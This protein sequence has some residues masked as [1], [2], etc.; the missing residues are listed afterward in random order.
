MDCAPVEI[1]CLAVLYVEL[2]CNYWPFYVFSNRSPRFPIV[3]FPN[4]NRLFTCVDAKSKT[5]FE[6]FFDSSMLALV[7]SETYIFYYEGLTALETRVPTA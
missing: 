1:V 7:F 2:S 5:F 4:L 6:V 3:S